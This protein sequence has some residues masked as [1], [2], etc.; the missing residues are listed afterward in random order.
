MICSPLLALEYVFKS[1]RMLVFIKITSFSLVVFVLCVVL[2][3]GIGTY[4]ILHC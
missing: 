2:E 4:W 1:V 3:L